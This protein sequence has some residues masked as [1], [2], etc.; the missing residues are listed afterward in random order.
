MK[1]RLQTLELLE[2]SVMVSIAGND[3]QTGIRLSFENR[4]LQMN[5]TSMLWTLHRRNELDRVQC[6]ALIRIFIED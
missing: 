3:T 5:V 1:S 2:D 4:G 6:A